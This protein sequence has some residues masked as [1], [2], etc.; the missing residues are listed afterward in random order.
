MAKMCLLQDRKCM[1]CGECLYC[2]LNKTK[3]CDN[4]CTC[5]GD[6]DFDY[7]GIEIDDILVNIDKPGRKTGKNK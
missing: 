1:D 5:L 3:L 7:T 6:S 4:C 2:D